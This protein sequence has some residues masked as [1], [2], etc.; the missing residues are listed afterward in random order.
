MSYQFSVERELTDY[1]NFKAIPAS[2]ALGAYIEDINLN[3]LSDDA[4]VELKEAFLEF[5]VLFFRDQPMTEEQHVAFAC[6]KGPALCLRWKAILKSKTSNSMN[7][8][9]LG[10]M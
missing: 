6:R 3:D 4:F 1:R 5:K 9:P 10:L 7:Y 2:G 8:P